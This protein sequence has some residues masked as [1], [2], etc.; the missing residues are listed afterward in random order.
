MPGVVA[1]ALPLLATMAA[2]RT[3]WA[4]VAVALLASAEPPPAVRRK[5]LRGLASNASGLRRLQGWQASN[6]NIHSAVTSW[7]NS[8]SSAEETYG[9]ISTWDT[10]QVTNMNY[11][12]CSRTKQNSG[13]CGWHTCYSWYYG[14]YTCCSYYSYSCGSNDDSFSA[15]TPTFPSSERIRS[16]FINRHFAPQLLFLIKKPLICLA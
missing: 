7:L 15:R 9:H 3:A 2:R 6:G 13:C 14:Y 10:S 5:E 4:W 16:D 8:R 1:A 11:L 12:F